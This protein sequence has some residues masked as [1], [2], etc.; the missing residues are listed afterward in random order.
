M[1]PGRA[2][3]AGGS[4]WERVGRTFLSNF[5]GSC[6]ARRASWPRRARHICC[7]PKRGIAKHY[8]L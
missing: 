8:G 7:L 2:H 6:L 1:P 5:Y 3:S 4:G